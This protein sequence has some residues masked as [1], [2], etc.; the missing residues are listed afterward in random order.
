MTP[1]IPG[2]AFA[3]FGIAMVALGR[4]GRRH[5]EDLVPAVVPEL[6]RLKD[7]RTIRRGAT[8]CVV[9]GAFCLLNAVVFLVIAQVAT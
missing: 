5:A 3:V 2:L 4:W 6:R 1:E 9:F 7:L 8:S